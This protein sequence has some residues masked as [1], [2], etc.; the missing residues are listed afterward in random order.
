M[1]R[2]CGRPGAA[3][4]GLAEAQLDE[5]GARELGRGTEATP[6]G[7]EAGAEARDDAAP[8]RRRGRGSRPTVRLG[9]AAAHRL[10]QAHLLAHGADQRVGLRE[11][12]VP[13]ADPRLPQ[14]LHDPAERRHA[15]ALHGR[16]VGPGV[17]GA[18]VGRAEDGHGPSTRARQRLGGRHVDGVEVGALLPVHLDGDEPLGQ[19]GRRRRVLEALV[20]HHVAP[21]ARGVA[22]GE[23]DGLV[24]VTGP[25]QRL[26]S[27][28]EP[29]HRVLGVLAE[30]RARLVGE[31]VH[32]T[33]ARALRRG[34][35]TAGCPCKARA[36]ELE[37]EGQDGA[38][39]RRQP[40]YRAGHGRPLRRGGRE[41][42][43]LRR[44]PRRTWPGRRR[45]SF[46]AASPRTG[47]GGWRPTSEGPRTP[48]RA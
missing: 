3:A 44:A 47:S 22:D 2:A 30:I 12:L 4:A 38:D 19:V 26:V 1:W 43:D 36:M 24:L 39:H 32:S 14:R 15:V 48:R 37:L 13:L 25:P 9:P 46:E 40:G 29:L 28:G 10:G 18:A 42:H 20:G 21:V 27:P 5:G 45:D 41:R 16:E 34:A 31:A 33:D 8:R 7:V 35:G 17:E 23:E 6:L 11:D